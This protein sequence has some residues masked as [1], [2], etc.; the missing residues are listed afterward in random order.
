[1]DVGLGARDVDDTRC[2]IAAMRRS[3]LPTTPMCR[4][5]GHQTIFPCNFA[6]DPM[7][8]SGGAF[9]RAWAHTITCVPAWHV[10]FVLRE[11]VAPEAA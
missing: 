5:I 6:S 2:S 1:M 7:R 8:F 3:C 11:G 4:G 9:G 10:V